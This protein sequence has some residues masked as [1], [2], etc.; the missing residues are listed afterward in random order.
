MTQELAALQW[1][2]LGSLGVLVIACGLLLLVV[3]LCLNLS[4]MLGKFT[5]KSQRHDG[6]ESLSPPVVLV[7]SSCRGGETSPLEPG[8]QAE[9]TEDLCWVMGSGFQLL[10]GSRVDLLRRYGTT[11]GGERWTGMH[12][13]H[14][15]SSIP[16]ES[17]KP[18]A[19]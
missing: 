7:V 16:A 8:G 17:L 10:A 19:P 5:T 13:G 14:F 12:E 6:S 11:T 4:E 15:F 9:V 2:L 18:V 3:W 1:I